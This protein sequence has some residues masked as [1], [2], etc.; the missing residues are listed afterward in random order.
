MCGWEDNIIMDPRKIGWE[1]VDRM[2]L[3]QDRDFG[4][5]KRRGI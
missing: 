5:H 2:H 4:F 3:A 1:A